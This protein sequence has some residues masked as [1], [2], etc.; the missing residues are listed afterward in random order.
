MGVT[1]VNRCWIAA[2]RIT[3]ET[4]IFLHL[5]RD[6]VELAEFLIGNP[7]KVLDGKLERL[8]IKL[9]VIHGNAHR[10]VILG[11]TVIAFLHVG[12]E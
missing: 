10:E 12:L 3:H 2:R 7:A 5:R 1:S 11:V 8:G 6:A 9:R 4:Q